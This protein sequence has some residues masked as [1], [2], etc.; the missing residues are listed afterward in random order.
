MEFAG[1]SR[2]AGRAKEDH[3][4]GT[5]CRSLGETIEEVEGGLGEGE[6]GKIEGE[7]GEG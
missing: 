3:R 5:G 6:K 1:R 7:K 4:E 2:A